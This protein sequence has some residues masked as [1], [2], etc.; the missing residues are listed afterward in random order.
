MLHVL[1]HLSG[2]DPDCKLMAGRYWQPR[3]ARFLDYDDLAQEGALGLIRAVETFDEGRGFQFGTYARWWVRQAMSRAIAEKARVIRLPEYLSGE[4]KR[5]ARVQGALWQEHHQEP[6][7][8]Q[9]TQ[10]MECA[11][12][13]VV[14]LMQLRQEV[15]SLE[16]EERDEEEQHLGE[17]LQAPDPSQQREEQASVTELLDH[18]N[19]RE[20]RVIVARYQLGQGAEHGVEDIPVPYSVAARQL[21]MTDYLVKQVEERALLKMRYWA[22]RG[23]RLAT[24]SSEEAR[25]LW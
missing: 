22:E 5:L 25:S 7:V 6:I 3:L 16:D 4:L 20:R 14:F 24:G 17:R 15:L 12:R 11:Q 1:L 21:E 13:Q 19:P 2:C 9:M 8:E 10:A 18:L 23:D